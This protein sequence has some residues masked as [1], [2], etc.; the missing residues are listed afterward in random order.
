MEL[1]EI[2]H[3]S[4]SKSWFS[5]GIHSLLRRSE[6]IRYKNDSVFAHLKHF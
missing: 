4:P 3:K 1:K 2:L 5:N 6:T